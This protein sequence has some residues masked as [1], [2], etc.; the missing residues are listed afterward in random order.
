MMGV[1][2]GCGGIDGT[3]PVLAGQSDQESIYCHRASL[4][5]WLTLGT[6]NG[7]MIATPL[8]GG[9]CLK[10]APDRSFCQVVHVKSGPW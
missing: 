8:H 1:L 2:G 5:S 7:N 10:I 3:A 6:L 4:D 9:Q